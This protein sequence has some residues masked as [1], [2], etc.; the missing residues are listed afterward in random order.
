[1]WPPWN[2]VLNHVLP[3]ARE[4]VKIWFNFPLNKKTKYGYYHSWKINT[5]ISSI[6]KLLFIFILFSKHN[7][8]YQQ[9]I[10][11]SDCIVSTKEEEVLLGVNIVQISSDA[12]PVFPL[13]RHWGRNNKRK[14]I[15]SVSAETKTFWQ[16]IFFSTN[17]GV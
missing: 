6:I 4:C 10:P 16:Y 14:V 7:R 5:R 13:Q 2:E 15:D 8:L 11:F 1:M 12:V 3:D 17:Q 9:T